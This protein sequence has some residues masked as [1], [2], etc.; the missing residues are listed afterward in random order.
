MLAESIAIVLAPKHQPNSGVFH[1]TLAGMKTLTVSGDRDM[2]ARAQTNSGRTDERTDRL[3]VLAWAD[4]SPASLC[5]LSRSRPLV[6]HCART[7]FHKHEEPFPLY[8]IAP[9][10]IWEADPRHKAQFMDLRPRN[11][12]GATQPPSQ[13]QH[14]PH[15]HQPGH[16]HR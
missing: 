6:Q 14:Q 15:A 4:A 1:C 13:H 16:L 3:M 7:G 2:N 5:V 8:S 9:H 10:Y 11:R 12:Q